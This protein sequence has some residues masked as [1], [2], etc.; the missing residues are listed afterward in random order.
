M[1]LKT[2]DWDKPTLETLGIPAEILP[3]I[4][5]NSEIIGKIGK[6]WPISGCLGDQHSAM[7]GQ[8]CK[9]GEAKSTYGTGDFILMN[10][11]KEVVKSKH[12]LMS[13]VFTK[14]WPPSQWCLN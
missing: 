2:L 11:G 8:A 7:L 3:K 14:N 4:V 1:N 10:T 9:K 13:S 6:G 12:G 5:S